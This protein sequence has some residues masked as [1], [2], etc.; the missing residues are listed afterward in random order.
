MYLKIHFS[1]QLKT[2]APSV[3]LTIRKQAGRYWSTPQGTCEQ[4]TYSV[5]VLTVNSKA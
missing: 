5:N 3:E 2:F 1:V 4:T